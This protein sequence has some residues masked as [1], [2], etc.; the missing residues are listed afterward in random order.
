LEVSEVSE[1]RDW[2]AKADLV[3]KIL[4]PVVIFFLGTMYS[5]QQKRI[6]VEQKS[7]DRVTNLAKSLSSANAGEQKVA[8]ALITREKQLHPDLIPTD[9]LPVALPEVL[10]LATNSKNPEVAAQ[11]QQL[12]LDLGANTN[13]VQEIKTSIIQPRIYMQ[14]PDENLR[15][16]AAQIKGQLESLSYIVPG[17][18][19]VRA[20]TGPTQV[21]YFKTTE[22]PEAK[23]IA[24]QLRT[25]GVNDAKE[26]YIPGSEDSKKMRARHYEVWFGPNSFP[27]K[28]L[29][30]ATPR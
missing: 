24:E 26:I 23:T 7:L 19:K 18:E 11:A 16:Q 17:I 30:A 22:M 10:Q 21:K 14:I 4:T 3:S 8:L 13:L 6:D 15:D 27:T 25:F 12:A 1:K 20:F 2:Y 28:P 9:I 5:C 29:S